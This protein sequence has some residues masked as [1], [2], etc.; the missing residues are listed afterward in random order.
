MQFSFDSGW[1]IGAAT[2]ERDRK[3]PVDDPDVLDRR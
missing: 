3:T 1:E 2:T